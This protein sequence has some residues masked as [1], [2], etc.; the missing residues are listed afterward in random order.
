MP[1]A[2][3]TPRSS[4]VWSERGPAPRGR[5]ARDTRRGEGDG[6]GLKR[7]HGPHSRARPGTV[8]RTRL[9]L[10]PAHRPGKWTHRP[11]DGGAP[12]GRPPCPQGCG[13]H[14]FEELLSREGSRRLCEDEERP[15]GAC[16]G[17]RHLLGTVWRH[18]GCWG[19]EGDPFF[20]DGPEPSITASAPCQAHG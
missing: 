10:S 3:S 2:L 13:G 12:M 20:L 17:D 15:P 5:G 16:G 4:P 8:A 6:H 1:Q 18:F 11:D 7:D 9:S 14:G 19:H